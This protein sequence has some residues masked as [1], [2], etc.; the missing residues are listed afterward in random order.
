VESLPETKEPV[1]AANV[2]TGVQDTVPFVDL[3]HTT[4]RVRG[5]ILARLDNLLAANT[6]ANGPQVAEFEREFAAWCGARY[7]VGVASGLDALR[8]GLL[9]AGI[10]PGDEV[11]VPALT[12]I[13]IF[14]A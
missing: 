11:V 14:E 13:A 10:G 12:F 4:E 5:E 9:A 7:C 8:L 6:F 1:R 2:G 3:T